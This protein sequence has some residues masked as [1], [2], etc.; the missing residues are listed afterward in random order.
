MIGLVAAALV[1]VGIVQPLG[2]PL[3]GL[4]NFVGYVVWSAWLVA[5]AVKLLVR[6]RSR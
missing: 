4:A 6:R 2:V 1:A 3:A 5:V